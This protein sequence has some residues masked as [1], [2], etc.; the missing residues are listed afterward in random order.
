MTDHVEGLGVRID[1][2]NRELLWQNTALI[3]QNSEL[4][5]RMERMREAVAAPVDQTDRVCCPLCTH[6]FKLPE[7]TMLY[8]F[9]DRLHKIDSDRQSKLRQRRE[10]RAQAKRQ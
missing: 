9:A 2:I 8:K 7:L 1:S 10:R 3:E 5:A 4:R 6:Y